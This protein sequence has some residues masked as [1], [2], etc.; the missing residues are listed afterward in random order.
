MTRLRECREAA[1]I[2]QKEVAITLGVRSPS[3]SNWERG[4]TY[5]THENLVQ[6]ANLYG[7]SVDFLTGR[8][9]NPHGV[10][11]ASVPGISF[12]AARAVPVLGEICCGNGVDCRE[13]HEGEFFID[14]SIRADFCLNVRGDSM[15]DVWIK[16]GDIAFF[17]REFDF[18][19]GDLYAVL[20]K[21]E[22]LAKIRQVFQKKSKL[23]LNPQN[24]AN[25]QY[26]PEVVDA[27]NVCIIG[28]YVGVF[29]KK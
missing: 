2:S 24:A 12:P 4:K 14:R 1:G 23:I 26:E 5:P 13:T 19:S 28:E 11:L 15:I 22:N 25:P 8:T 18:K 9:D 21:S 10:D 17:K 6:L 27:D 16:N 3:V 7:V 20:E 29:H